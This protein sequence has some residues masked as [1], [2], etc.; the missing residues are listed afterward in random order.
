MVEQQEVRNE[1]DAVS[2]N[3]LGLAAP[4]AKMYNPNEV[5]ENEDFESSFII[6][7]PNELGKIWNLGIA[8]GMLGRVIGKAE[9]FGDLDENKLSYFNSC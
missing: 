8:Q 3:N 1:T 7:N 5:D 9:T 4:Q 6:N 2:S